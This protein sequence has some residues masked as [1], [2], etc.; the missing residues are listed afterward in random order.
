MQGE[1]LVI[2]ADC[3]TVLV[4]LSV[5]LLLVIFILVSIITAANRVVTSIRILIFHFI[6]LYIDFNVTSL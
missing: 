5:I 6:C 1:A 3:H 2:L 4:W